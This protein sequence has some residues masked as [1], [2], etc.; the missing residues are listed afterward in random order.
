VVTSPELQ[1]ITPELLRAIPERTTMSAQVDQLPLDRRERMVLLL[2]DGQRTV[3]DLTRLIRRSQQEVYAV[4][5]H[6][7]LLRLIEF[8]K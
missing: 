4:L 2:V 6:L 8:R 5:Y 3:S 7:R 1:V